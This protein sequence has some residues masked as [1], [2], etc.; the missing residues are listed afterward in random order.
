MVLFETALGLGEMEVLLQ[1]ADQYNDV[2]FFTKVALLCTDNALHLEH[3][4]PEE[5]QPAQ[6]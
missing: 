5:G 4:Q 6:F 2:S 1:I 3:V